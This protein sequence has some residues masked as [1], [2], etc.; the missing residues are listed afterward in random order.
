MATTFFTVSGNTP[1]SSSA[2]D[3]PSE[4]ASSVTGVVFFCSTSWTMS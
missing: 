1:E 4:C 2:I 3:P